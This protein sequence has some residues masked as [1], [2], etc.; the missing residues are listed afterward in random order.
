MQLIIEKAKKNDAKD[1]ARIHRETIKFGFLSTLGDDF[2]KNLYQ[3]IISS[4]YS[5]CYICKNHNK[6]FGFICVSLN[7]K[8]TYSEFLKRNLS[9]AIVIFIK[10]VFSINRVSKIFDHLFYNSKKKDLPNAE[11]L[12]VAVVEEFKR[13]KIGSELFNHAMNYF[14]ENNIKDFVI[15]TGANNIESNEYFKKNNCRL[16]RKVSIHR[17]Q[18]SNIY[19]KKVK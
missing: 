2:L 19:I 10:N 3:F 5:R 14:K 16:S 15:T 9:L 17:K 7:S 18:N 6:S 8:K 4:N 11:L 13:K 12:S 1:I